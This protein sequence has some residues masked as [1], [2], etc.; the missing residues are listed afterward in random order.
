[1]RRLFFGN[2]D[3]EAKLTRPTHRND[4]SLDHVL[5]ELAPAWIAIA[6]DGDLIWCPGPIEA[7]FFQNLTHS[8]LAR[9]Q[10]ISRVADIP[11]DCELVPWGWTDE[12]V[13]WAA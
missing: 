10:P 11:R 6:R 7:S 5:A 2:F 9:V 1:M 12:I 3:F 13:K 4:A 8:G